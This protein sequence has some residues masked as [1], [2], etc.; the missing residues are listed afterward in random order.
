[1]PS[2]TRSWSRNRDGESR[3]IL[4]PM[5]SDQ[6]LEDFQNFTHSVSAARLLMSRAHDNGSLIEGL[7]L[8]A[9]VIDAFLR[10]LIAHATGEREGTVT[11]LDLRYFRHDETLWMNERKVYREAQSCGVLSES[12]RCELDELYDFR[13]VV[14]HRFI[15]SGITYDQIGPRLD[16]CEAIFS[17]L[18]AQL[19]SIEQPAPAL[20]DAQIGAVRARIARKLGDPARDV[21]P[22]Q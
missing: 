10:V 13:N 16:Q 6:A 1:V 8:Y 12:D 9:S 2:A 11:H 17:R 4:K 21:R 20:S 22:P 7:V 19:E 5:S 15:I 18:R 3:V 14:I